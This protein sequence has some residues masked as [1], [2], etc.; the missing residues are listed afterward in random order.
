MHGSPRIA[1]AGL[2]L[3]EHGHRTS[4]ADSAAVSEAEGPQEHMMQEMQGADVID[5]A[6]EDMPNNTEDES[7]GL[8]PNKPKVTA[9]ATC[10]SASRSISTA[11][12]HVANC[13]LSTLACFDLWKGC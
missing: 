5:F 3:S 6:D 4:P 7:A 10:S 11:H 9:G 1:A 12:T 8:L 13:S 2:L